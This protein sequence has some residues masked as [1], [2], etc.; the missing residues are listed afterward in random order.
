[1]GVGGWEEMCKGEILKL[2]PDAGLVFPEI[3]KRM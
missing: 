3:M 2:R 1:M